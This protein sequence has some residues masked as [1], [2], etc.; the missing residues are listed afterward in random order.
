VAS[1]GRALL[2]FLRGFVGPARLP[3]QADAARA[4]LEE[5]CSKRGSCC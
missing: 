3:R 5:R 4:V 2:G 1:F